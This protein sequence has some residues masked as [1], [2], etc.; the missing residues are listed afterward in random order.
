MKNLLIATCCSFIS[1]ITFAFNESFLVYAPVYFFTPADNQIYSN[2]Q[3]K[4]L[5]A[6]DGTKI[7]WRNPKTGANGYI[8]PSSTTVANGTKCRQL[9]IYNEAQGATG[10][11]QVKACRINNAWKVVN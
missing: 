5:N 2:A 9:Q 11:S 7:S 1:T 8:I 3:Q 6:K 10:K 4:A